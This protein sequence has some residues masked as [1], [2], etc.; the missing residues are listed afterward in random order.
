MVTVNIGVGG[1]GKT[2]TLN[3]VT[4]AQGGTGSRVPTLPVNGAANSGNGGGGGGYDSRFGVPGFYKCSGGSGAVVLVVP[5]PL[6]PGAYP[7]IA[8]TS[9][10][11]PGKTILTFTSPG[12]Y[13]A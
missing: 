12:T 8:S 3:G 9:T 10:N 5:T 7:S 4:Y 13:T 11:A 6:Y 1:T 2:F